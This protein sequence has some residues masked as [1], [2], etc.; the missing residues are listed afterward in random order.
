MQPAQDGFERL[1]QGMRKTWMTGDFGQLARYSARC[2]EEFVGR[3]EIQ[4]GMRVL[5]VACGTGNL[6]IPAARM[7]SQVTGVDFAT[8]LLEQARNRA[9]A[10]RLD[11]SFK[12]GD[13]E[14]LPFADG[15]F[16]IVMSMFGAMFPPRPEI[17]AAELARVCRPGGRIAMA[18]WTPEG[19]IGQVFKVG[20][21][22][23]AP[24]EGVPAPALWG[25]E[26]V[27][28]E[29]LGTHAS[30]ISMT[31]R[32]AEFDFPFQPAGVV[33]FFREYFGP[34]KIAFSRLDAEQQPAYAADLEKL[35]A[36]AQ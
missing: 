16:D 35:W 26:D 19:F 11:A 4:A 34:I 13:A 22:Y 33:A 7:G 32:M 21:R 12:E 23:I 25:V 27:V 5:D 17:V 18:N 8:N 29:R 36:G 20:A 15:Q 30:K 1:K 24:P 14:Q 6:A 10:E 31:K 3:L 9:A 28:R 2:A